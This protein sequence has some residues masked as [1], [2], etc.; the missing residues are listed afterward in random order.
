ME[1]ATVRKCLSCTKA[2]GGSSGSW[3]ASLPTIPRAAEISGWQGR[4]PAPHQVW[5]VRQSAAT[6]PAAHICL[7]RP[8]HVYVDACR[9]TR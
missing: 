5:L 4:H 9:H 2:G 7:R 8:T 1:K 6:P 3:R